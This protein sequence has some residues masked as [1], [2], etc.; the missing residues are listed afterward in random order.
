MTVAEKLTRLYGDPFSDAKT[1]EAKWMT[2]F[3]YPED[4][5]K[6]IPVIGNSIYCNKDLVATYTQFLRLLINR[7]LH[8]EIRVNDQCF[9]IRLVRGSN[10]PSVHSWGMAVDLNPIDNP[11]G[12]SYDMAHAKG[13]KPFSAAFQQTARDVGYICGIDFKRPDG[14]HFELTKHLR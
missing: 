3:V 4:V 13:L 5:R 14:M 6:A 8:Q 12:M 10:Q 11:L 9:C 1:F 2:N 7:K